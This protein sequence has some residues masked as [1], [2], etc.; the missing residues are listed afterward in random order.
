MQFGTYTGS[1]GTVTVSGLP[2]QPRFV[3]TKNLDGGD[4]WDRVYV[5]DT[6]RGLGKLVYLNESFAEGDFSASPTVSVTTDGFTVANDG[7]SS[8]NA[9][10]ETF[11]YWVIK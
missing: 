5:Q 1:S 9:N 6:V 3:V 11:F 2:F 8:I 7:D 10:G 4:A